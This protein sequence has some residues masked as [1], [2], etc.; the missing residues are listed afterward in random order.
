MIPESTFR[1][2]PFIEKEFDFAFVAN[3]GR[4]RDLSGSN[5]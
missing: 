4:H 5:V 3:S 1:P 2:T